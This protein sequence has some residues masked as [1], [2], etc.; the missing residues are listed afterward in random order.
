[1]CVASLCDTEQWLNSDPSGIERMAEDDSEI[2]RRILAGERE[3]FRLLVD[4]HKHMVFGMIMRQIGT[5]E[6]AEEIAQETFCR[7]YLSLKHF[8]FESA[9]ATW[10]TRIALNQTSTYFASRRFKESRRTESFD[11]A[12]HDSQGG[13]PQAGQES[14]ATLMAFRGAIGALSPKLRE[15]L[16]L[17]TLEQKSY[18]EV[19]AALG[20]PVGTVRSRLNAARLELRKLLPEFLEGQA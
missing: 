7:A 20:I 19:A 4:K 1:M 13:D 9:F 5:R 18:E 8:R 14:K 17:C 12:Q 3:D 16:V 10:L 11:L 6:I 15:V 2:V